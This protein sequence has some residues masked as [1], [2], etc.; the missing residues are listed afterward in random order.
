MREAVEIADPA[1]ADAARNVAGEG[2][3]G[4]A[5]GADDRAGLD[6]GED[7]ALHAV[8]EVGGMDQAEGGRSKHLLLLPRRV[9]WRTSGEEFHSLKATA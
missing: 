5:V 8:G 9:V 4:V 3:I 6:Q 2:R 1:A 7:V